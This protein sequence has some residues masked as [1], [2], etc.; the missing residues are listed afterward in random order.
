MLSAIAI[1]P[2]APLLVPQLV[3]AAA[4]ELTNLR[5]A[6]FAAAGALPQQWVAIGVGPA[7]EFVG[8][9]AA[10]TFA[11]YG[12]DVRVGLSPDADTVGELPLCALVTGWVRSHARPAARAEVRVVAH[13]AEGDDALRCGRD[14]RSTID[15][16]DHDVGVLVVADGANTLTARAPGGYDSE[17]V[18]VQSALDDALASGDVAALARLPGS[19][20]GRVAWQ[21]LAGLARTPPRSVKE[22]YRGAPFGVG[23]FVGVWVPEGRSE[24]TGELTE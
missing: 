24:A 5:R 21:V 7:D 11:G 2:S 16:A 18:A 22:L 12:V 19:I 3:G 10:G 15:A 20:S 9:E 6:V 1:V 13:T 4:D 8:P 23:Y 14:L 17:S